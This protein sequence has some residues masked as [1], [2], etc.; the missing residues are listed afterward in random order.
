MRAAALRDADEGRRRTDLGKRPEA[1]EQY[2]KALAIREKLVADFP[3]VPAYR[4]ELGGSFG[5]FSNMI[6]DGG[7]PPWPSTFSVLFSFTSAPGE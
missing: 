6:R 5:N 7:N 4:V 2:L 3:A 1:E